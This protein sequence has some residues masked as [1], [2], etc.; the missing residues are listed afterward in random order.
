MV[1]SL[2]GT[3]AIRSAIEK[4]MK[5]TPTNG[6]SFSDSTLDEAAKFTVQDM[7]NGKIQLVSVKTGK[8]VN[9]YYINDVKCE[10]PGGGLSMGVVYLANGFVLLT[11]SGYSGQDGVTAFLSDLPGNAAYNGSLAVRDYPDDHTRF[12]IVN[13]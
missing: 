5:V 13:L 4:Y 8:H 7:G 12:F 2:K 3:V 11:I 6:L 1:A 9:M 10:G